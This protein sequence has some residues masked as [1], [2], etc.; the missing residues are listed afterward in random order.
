MLPL[1]M[2]ARLSLRYDREG[3]ILYI[4][5]CAAYA[6]Q[7]SEELADDIILG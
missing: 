6:A 4:D 2:A 7:V 1:G 5:I 3:D